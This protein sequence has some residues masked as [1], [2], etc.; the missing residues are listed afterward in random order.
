MI[1]IKNQNA[2]SLVIPHTPFVLGKAKRN[3]KIVACIKA[4]M[5]NHMWTDNSANW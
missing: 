4:W 1:N 5:K 3:V 2:I